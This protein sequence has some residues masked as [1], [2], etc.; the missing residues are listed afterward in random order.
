VVASMHSAH[1][2]VAPSPMT[3]P[4]VAPGSAVGLEVIPTLKTCP[5]LSPV[6]LTSLLSEPGN[7]LCQS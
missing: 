3:S 6:P 5:P 4:T 2:V 1:S 7:H